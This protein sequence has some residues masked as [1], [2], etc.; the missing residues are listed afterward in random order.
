MN[1]QGTPHLR[2]YSSWLERNVPGIGFIALGRRSFGVM[3]LAYFLFFPLLLL[4]NLDTFFNAMESMVL[5]AFL[6]LMDFDHNALY[7]RGDVIEHWIAALF[8]VGMPVLLWR[9]NRRRLRR[10]V[11]DGNEDEMSQWTLAW[12]EFKKNRLAASAMVIIILLYTVTFL[13]PFLA[14]FHPNAFQDGL[15]TKYRPPL[16]SV[17][18]LHL[19]SERIRS[20]G[21]ESLRLDTE[22]PSVVRDLIAANRELAD[23]G[24]SRQWAVDAFRVEGAEVMATVKD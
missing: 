1:D 3:L 20:I 24:F 15:V 12:R 23:E 14:P 5:S 21:I 22:Y 13:C 9:L 8:L 17:T 6:T 10:I 7:M 4:L 2:G 11:L 16:S 18:V 19:R